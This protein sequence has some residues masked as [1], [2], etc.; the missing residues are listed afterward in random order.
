MSGLVDILDEMAA[1]IRSALSDVPKLQVTPRM[2]IN[3]TPPTID[4]YPGDPF[5]D[6]ASAG[7]GD[8]NGM[9]IFTVRARINTADHRNGQTRLFRMMDDEHP[10]SVA[11]ALHGDDLNG[12]VSSTK[13]DGP[14]GLVQYVEPNG[15]GAYLGCEWRVTVINAE[16]DG[17]E[18]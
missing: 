15:E 10:W 2:N 1:T 6:P 8:V 11:N 5:R 14:S 13:V 7:F 16:P 12:K 17:A 9:L 3:P 4:I 18:S